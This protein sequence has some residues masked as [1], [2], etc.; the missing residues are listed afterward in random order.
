MLSHKTNI[1]R[2]MIVIIM[3]ILEEIHLA[4]NHSTSTR[5]IYKI[6][7]EKYCTYYDMTLHELLLEAE[8]E[9]DQQIKWKHR[10][11][12][13]RLIEY[14]HHLIEHYPKNTVATYFGVILSIYYYFEIEIGPLPGLDK[15]SYI[16]PAPITFKDL[17]D[18]DI[19]R[20]SLEIATPVMKAIILFMSSSGCARTE[21]L[22]ITIAD[23][24]ESVKEYTET[25]DIMEMI[26]TLNKI[27]D[28][29][30]TFNILRVK[31]KK[32]YTTYCSPEAVHAINSYL[33]TRSNLKPESPLFK[34]HPMYLMHKFKEINNELGLGKVGSYHRFRSHMLRKF[35][36]SAL[37]NDGMSIDK[38][39]DLQGKSKTL[40]D[41]SYFMVNP[42]D[43]KQEYINH[44]HA[45]LMSVDVEKLSVKSPEY[46]KLEQENRDL[47]VKND[48]LEDIKRRVLALE[49]D[50]PSWDQIKNK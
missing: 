25:N 43:L 19:I 36:A 7:A 38:V 8:K 35:H 44:L 49:E 13:R 24:M 45:L 16:R 26:D 18:K 4:K 39:N 14:R 22:N 10:R 31:T 27:E 30:P 21:T 20:A 1:I 6:A 33:L 34:T 23:Y 12:K 40:T 17:P 11:L 2:G 15:K 32:Y 28:V 37:Y 48:D 46:Y 41:Q 9:E 5:N 47:K 50:R 3:N 29:I 42:E